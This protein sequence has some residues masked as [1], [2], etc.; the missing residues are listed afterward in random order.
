MYNVS[1][2]DLV[3]WNN[4]KNNSLELGQELVIKGAA[5]APAVR[6]APVAPVAPAVAPV[7]EV[8]EEPVVDK[9]PA[10]QPVKEAPEEKDETVSIPVVSTPAD[11]K[12]AKNRREVQEAG[13]ADR[14][15]DEGVNQSKYYALHRSAPMGTIIMVRNVSNERSVFVKVVGRLE[16]ADGTIIQLSKS[17]ADQLKAPN[18]RFKVELLYGMAA[19]K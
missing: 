7:K 13:E 14:I 4:I 6:P 19:G 10:K 15:V 11:I 3:K 5:A 1:P 17:A 2:A 9:V 16:S 18:K 8:V 12:F